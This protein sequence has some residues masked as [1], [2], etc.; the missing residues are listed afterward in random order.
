MWWKQAT[1]TPTAKAIAYYR[2]SAQDRQEYSIPIQREQVKN[3]AKEHSIKI[4]KDFP[5]YGKSGLSSKGR[6][7]FLEMLEYVAEGKEE[8]DYILVLDV[9]RWGR[10]QDLVLAPYYIGLCQQY[11]KKVIFTDIGFPKEDDLA[12]FLRLNVESYRAATYSKE[13]SDKVFKGCVNIAK[14]GFRAGGPPPYGL[15]RLLLDE[16]QKPVQILK[17]GQRKS[18]Q[19]QRVTLTS[20]DKDE[21][22]VVKTIFRAFVEKRC[23]PK[24]IAERLNNEQIPSPGQRQWTGDSVVS[25]LNNEFYIGTMVYNK[26]SQKLQSKTKYNPKDKWIRTEDAFEAIVEKELFHQAQAIL[27]TMVQERLRKYSDEDMLSKLK[28]LYDKCG[29]VSVKQISARKDMVSAATY[30][31]HF[32]SLDMAFQ[33]MFYK[34]LERTRKT[35]AEQLGNIAKR[36]EQFED[37][38]VLNDSLSVLVQP[39]VPVPYG[40]GVYWSFRP[41]SR[42]EIDI[43]LGVPLSNNGQYDIVGY[44]L[45]PRLLLQGHNIKVFGGSYGKL[46]LYGYSNLDIIDSVLF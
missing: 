10:F 39:S 3:F 12:H 20:G 5:D 18:I 24:D 9:S 38:F 1:V 8:F 2:H 15:C 35:V 27:N 25:I 46:D 11:G 4:I 45:F 6:D 14:H 29:I 22:A 33:N 31:K 19:N 21:I 44:L 32:L 30:S 43:T 7:K 13:L 41:D 26:T 34:I 40:Y 16:Q 42:I 23:S 36:I 37:Y 28:K 17:P